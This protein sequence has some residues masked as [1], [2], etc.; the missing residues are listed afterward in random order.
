[1]GQNP[2]E[3]LDLSN[4]V[5]YLKTLMNI[6]HLLYHF[7]LVT[8]TG[9]VLQCAERKTWVFSCNLDPCVLLFSESFVLYSKFA[10][11]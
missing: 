11:T 7:L 6:I 1:V 2:T 8:L 10:L 4:E 3:T 9:M 5:Q